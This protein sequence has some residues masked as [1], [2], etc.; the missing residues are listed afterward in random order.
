MKK[1]LITALIVYLAVSAVSYGAFSALGKNGA[2][3]SLL[4]PTGIQQAAIPTPDPNNRIVIAPEAPRNQECPL[5]GQMY[6]QVEKDSWSKRRPLAVM[7]ENHVDARPQSG[8]SSADLVYETVVEGGI[9]RFMG[10]YY[11]Q[12]QAKDVLLAPIRS[13]RQFF[14]DMASE[15]NRPLYAHVGGANGDNSDP[16]VRALEHI[17]DYGWNQ[18]TDLNQFSIGYPTFVRNYDR[19]PGKT[20]LATEHTMETSTERLWAVGA[21][22]GWTDMSPATVV[23][24]KTI[25]GSEWLTGFVK[26]AF[27]DEATADARGT[28]STIAYEFW[29][30][31]KDFAVQ[32]NYDKATNA[33]A[34]VLAGQPHV[35]SDTGKQITSKNVLVLQMKE[36]PSVDVEHHNYMTTIGTGDGWLFQDGKAIKVTWTKKDREGRLQVTAL[37]KPVQFV[38]GQIWISVINTA[39]TPTF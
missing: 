27:K 30:G 24:G 38:R 39:T 29:S 18:T 5:N 13:A 11:C 22:R 12:A 25:P 36:L 8:L 14:L 21:K 1:T 17:S 23:K 10:V 28:T 32:W 34:R 2:G 33:Y 20:D 4:N 3:I 26:W 7:I 16:R 19:I 37:G 15:Y 6:T 9:T 35:D 31:Y